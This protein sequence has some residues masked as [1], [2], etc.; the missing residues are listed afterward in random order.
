ME[1]DAYRTTEM[2]VALKTSLGIVYTW[3]G[4]LDFTA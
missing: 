2:P 3:S 1:Q 4:S